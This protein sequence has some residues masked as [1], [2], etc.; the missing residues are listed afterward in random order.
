MDEIA[1]LEMNHITKKFPGV[2]ALNDVSFRVKKGEIHGLIGENGAGKST[3]MKILG[4]SYPTGT[5]EGE[6]RLDGQPLDLRSP[7]T[8]LGQGIAVVPQE[9]NVVNEL[10]VAENVVVGR[11]APGKRQVINM[12]AIIRRVADFLSVN[13][14]SLDPRQTVIRLTAA[15]KQE[16]MIARALYTNP[17][18][19]ILDEPTSSLSLNE[20]ENL[21][22]ILRDLRAKGVTCVF[23]THKLAEIFQ[24]TDRTTVLRDGEVAGEFAQ[25]EYDEGRIITAMVGRTIDQLYPARDSEYS[26]DEVLR[27]EDL[28]IPHAIIANRNMVDGVSLSLRRGEI[29]G[30]AGL[31]GSGRSEVLN[32]IYGRLKHSGRILVEGKEVTIR[33]TTD[34]KQA[35][36]AL[37]TED[38]KKDGLLPELPVR[39]NLTVNNL[40]LLTHMFVLLNGRREKQV[41]TEYT[42]KLNIRTPSIETLVTSLSGG[43]QQKLVLGRVLLGQ[44]KILLLDEP[45]KGVDIGAKNEIYKI[46]LELAGQGISIIMVS[47]E[48]PELLAMC[49]R[50][51]VLADGK[52]VD[53]FE[54]AEASEHR[55]MLAATGSNG[56]RGTAEGSPSGVSVNAS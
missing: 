30:I 44:P 25:E 27:V 55:V 12:R 2:V 19:L 46:M 17:S 6:I 56:R 39:P 34:A 24:L 4:G 52:I 8:A 53:E 31:V 16:V 54:K 42:H 15:Q 41:A 20:I 48:L 7:H 51:L 47:S 14:L 37:V 35:G 26:H 18:V 29:L 23:I 43:N 10:N 38:R 50:F 5:Y 1:L 21:F 28:T 3:L 36:I 49:D 33:R 45:T 40:R 9:I 32:A 22:R 11:W 13:N